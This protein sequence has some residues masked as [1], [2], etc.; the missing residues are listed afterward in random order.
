MQ[1]GLRWSEHAR[2]DKGASCPWAWLTQAALRN[3]GACVMHGQQKLPSQGPGAGVPWSQGSAPSYVLTSSFIFD[4][5]TV[6][7]NC[8]G[9]TQTL[10]LSASASW[11]AKL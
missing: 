4:F 2:G 1:A 3:T 10:D 9:W 6:L 5:E 8:P 7:L 11:R